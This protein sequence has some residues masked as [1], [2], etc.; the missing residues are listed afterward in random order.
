[1]NSAH[2]KPLQTPSQ[3]HL[4]P[5]N[6]RQVFLGAPH[7]TFLLYCCTEMYCCEIQCSSRTPDSQTC[8]KLAGNPLR[9]SHS[10]LRLAPHL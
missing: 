1:L 8:V 7:A 4:V 3:G 9:I 5:I 2:G 10:K 6:T